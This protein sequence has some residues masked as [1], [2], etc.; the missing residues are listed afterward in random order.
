M[1]LLGELQ[2]AGLRLLLLLLD[3]L[4]LLGRDI[5]RVKVVKD[6]L[7]GVSVKRR[8]PGTADVVYLVNNR[9][10][11]LA[12]LPGR[13]Q[14]HVVPRL[15][16]F[17]LPGGTRQLGHGAGLPRRLLKLLVSTPQGQQK[18]SR[19]TVVVAVSPPCCRAV[20][21][22]AAS[23]VELD[24]LLV[25]VLPGTLPVSLRLS[26]CSCCCRR[27]AAAKAT[28][29]LPLA[30]PS[31]SSSSSSSAL[32]DSAGAATAAAAAAAAAPGAGDPDAERTAAYVNAELTTAIAAAP[33]IK[34][35]A[36]TPSA[37]GPVSTL[38]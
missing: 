25:V 24:T 38:W 3:G 26:W 9:C 2:F 22:A 7:E 31:S 15:H 19:T 27:M 4:W 29:S 17:L 33:A 28:S 8:G 20:F 37:I 10:V 12:H 5:D 18:R 16:G 21:G 11:L 32:A 23:S 13:G 36:L 1:L 34:A 35:I 14:L 30:C 6:G